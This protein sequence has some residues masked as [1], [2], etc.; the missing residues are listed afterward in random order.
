MPIFK[1]RITHEKFRHIDTEPYVYKHE[2]N[3][4]VPFSWTFFW[5][6]GLSYELHWVSNQ[7]EKKGYGVFLCCGGGARAYLD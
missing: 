1:K 4:G 6:G 2:E 7:A 5:T 3:K